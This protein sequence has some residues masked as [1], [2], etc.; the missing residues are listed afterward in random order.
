MEIKGS[1]IEKQKSSGICICTGTGS[2]AWSYNICSLHKET[3]KKLIKFLP[4]S[5]V[6]TCQDKMIE[7]GRVKFHGNNFF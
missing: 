3:I 7:N 1:K 6:D 5:D 2:T 4:I